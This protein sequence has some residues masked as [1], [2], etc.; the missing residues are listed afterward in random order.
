MLIHRPR[1]TR[2]DHEVRLEA[3]VDVDAPGVERP[4]TLWFALPARHERH[5]TD[6]AD[7]FA[8]ALLP[9]AMALGEPMRVEGA[10]S[11]RLAAGMREYQRI[12]SAWKPELFR[13]VEIECAGLEAAVRAGG[14][15]GV[16]LAFSGG[17]D[18]FYTLRGHLEEN[19]PY[20][21]FRVTHCVM[22]NGFDEDGDL[23]DTGSFA[24]I[25]RVY[26][27]MMAAHG[28]EVLTVRTNLLRVLGRPVRAQSFAAFLTAPALLLGGLVARY[29][30]SSGCK[31]TTMGLYPDGSHVILDHLLA[32]E[33]METSHEDANVTRLEKILA[34]SRWP[35]TYA[36]L[37][38][39]F[40]ATGVQPGQDAIANCCACEKCVRTMVS[41]DLAGA[42]RNYSC[43]PRPLTRRAVRSMSYA[44]GRG[45]LF[46]PEIIELADRLGRKAVAT[47]LRLANL[48]N[49]T[50]R[51][52]VRAA[53]R[54]NSRLEKRSTAYASVAARPKR[55]LKRW[56]L[57][58]GWLY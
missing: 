53:T 37:R 43:F 38:V 27:P 41:L 32:T 23:E 22:I 1:V 58:R 55:L 57:G 35:D 5:V 40:G 44:D 50:T 7:G 3:A 20:A 42:L 9:L 2:T 21:P 28:V 34:L 14:P 16:G 8:A 31:F 46:M 18:S 39:C 54:A 4:P 51:R 48:L 19:E 29:Y 17:V 45:R 6:R 52:V 12:Q 13:E 49:L 33:T 56:G 47:D 25:Q 30:V 15:R 10:L 36:R 26:E 24:A 11:Y